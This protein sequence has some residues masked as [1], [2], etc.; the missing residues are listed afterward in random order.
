MR[1]H[2]NKLKLK[3]KLFDEHILNEAKGLSN[4]T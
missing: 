4:V 3:I 1:V 2:G